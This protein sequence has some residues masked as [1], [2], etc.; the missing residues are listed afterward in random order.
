MKY[1]KNKVSLAL[2]VLALSALMLSCKK[3][4]PPEKGIVDESYRP[5]KVSPVKGLRIAWDYRS[6]EQLAD[7]GRSPQMVRAGETTLVTTYEV[8]GNVFFRWSIDDG[9]IW[10]DPNLLFGKTTHQG[11]D[12]SY[13]MT[14]TDMKTNPSIISLQNGDLLAACAVHY[15]YTQP[16]SQ[17]AIHISYPAGIIVRKIST[18]DFSLSDEKEVYFNLG[19]DEPALLALPSGE[20][21]LYFSNGDVATDVGLLSAT[22]L[23]RNLLMR[24]VDMVHSTDGGVTWSGKL[25]RFGPDG[26]EQ[27]WVG[28]KTIVSRYNKMNISPSLAIVGDEIAMAFSDNDKVTYKPFTVRSPLQNSW[29]YAINGDTPDR[30]YAF[31]EI[32]PDIQLVADPTLLTLPSGQVLLSYETDN[33]KASGIRTMGVAI[34]DEGAQDFTKHTRPFGFLTGHYSKQNSLLLWDDYTV[35]ALTASD[36]ASQ[37]DTVPWM[38][39]GYLI[40]DLVLSKDVAREYPFFVGGHSAAN[41]EAKIAKSDAEIT[42]EAVVTDST[43]VAAASGTENGDGI[44]VYIDAPNLS[45]LD[46][47]AGISKF[48]VSSGGEVIRWDG[49]EGKWVVVGSEGI[50]ASVTE[51]DSGYGVKLVIPTN[52]LV[53]FN[54]EGIRLA[55]GLSDYIDGERGTTELL[56][57]CEDLRSSTW[58]GVTF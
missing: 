34:A 49:K 31:Y 33:G 30:E 28:A 58:L 6:F 50:V 2:A 14:I 46:V 51:S 42:I 3:S 38:I 56:S 44:Y 22:E 39:K 55:F 45:L 54:P 12:G 16:A 29:P 57:L 37:T 8:D 47:D 25:D 24:R 11:R 4:G 18:S 5:V 10:S 52:R 26:V 41:L 27:R 1:A 36:Y 32:L 7:R 40:E 9:V 53:D 17:P 35:A 21:H 13:T 48:W 20:V 19:C 23:N 15:Q 43:P